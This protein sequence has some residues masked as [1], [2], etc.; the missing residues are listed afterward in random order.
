MKRLTAKAMLGAPLRRAERE[1]TADA[2]VEYLGSERA[3]I[4]Y[5]VRT[6]DRLTN[7]CIGLMT[8]DG[9]FAA[10]ALFLSDRPKYGAIGTIALLSLLA[11]VGLLCTNLIATSSTLGRSSLN[12]AAVRAH[13]MKVVAARTIRFTIGLYL[14]GASLLLIVVQVLLGALRP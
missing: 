3:V 4:E 11:A 9:I 13:G 5:F 14:S 1:D 10:L 2:L 7:K 6:I 12:M 8:A